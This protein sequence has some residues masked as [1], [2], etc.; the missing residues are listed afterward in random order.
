MRL[1]LQTDYA[2]RALLYL[3][4]TTDRP[5]VGSI[6]AFYGISEHHLGKVIHQLG[7]LGYVRNRRGPGGGIELA[8]ASQA[9]SVGAIIRSFE[10]ST[11]LLDCID[12]AGVCVIQPTCLLRGVLAEGEQRMMAHFDS[13]T[14]AD[15]VPKGGRLEVVPL[16]P[17]IR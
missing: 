9:V 16:G 2:L 8:R 1:A 5:T 6:A 7:K 11:H 3:A 10:G 4:S 12:T 15:L 14:L 17:P 13:V